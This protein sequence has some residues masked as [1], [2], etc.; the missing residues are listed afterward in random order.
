[1]NFVQ[2]QERHNRTQ[3]VNGKN[4]NTEIRINTEIRKNGKKD[5]GQW[6]KRE[7]GKN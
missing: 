2:K 5:K 4:G 3:G 6:G 1:M 7:K